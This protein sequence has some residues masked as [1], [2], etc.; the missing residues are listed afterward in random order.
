[1]I[2]AASVDV[3]LVALRSHL[4]VMPLVTLLTFGIVRFRARYLKVEQGELFNS[5]F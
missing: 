4:G 5:R 3:Q 2:L 1:M